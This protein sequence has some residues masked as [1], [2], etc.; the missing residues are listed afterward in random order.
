MCDDCFKTSIYQ[1]DS[2]K[3]YDDFKTTIQN[4][5]INR[6]LVIIKREATDYFA[7]IDPYEFYRCSSC[8]QVWVE[9]IAEGPDRGFFLPEDKAIVQTKR[10][11]EKDKLR[12]LGCLLLI[13]AFGLWAIWKL[14][15]T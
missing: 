4:K 1:F 2:Q 15:A 9:R 6:K 11:K 5:C 12:R 3:A 10:L 8:G 14:L 13:L 7:S